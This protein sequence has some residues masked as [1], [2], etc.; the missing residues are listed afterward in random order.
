MKRTFFWL[1][2][3]LTVVG[4]SVLYFRLFRFPPACY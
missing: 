2:T 1:I 3:V 4:A